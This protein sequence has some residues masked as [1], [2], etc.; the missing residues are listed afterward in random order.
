MKPLYERQSLCFSCTACGDCCSTGN[1]YHVYLT[2]E[3]AEKIRKHLKLSKGWFRRRY[4][5]RLEYGELVAAS[6][7]DGR[8]IFLDSNKQ[9]KVYS[10]RPLQCSTYPFWPE[11]VSTSKAWQAEAARCEGINCGE[12]VP[13]ERIRRAVKACLCSPD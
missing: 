12:A 1:D 9:C 4:L 10:V 6:S 7:A 13:V 2:G 8:C 3:E 11:L 5:E